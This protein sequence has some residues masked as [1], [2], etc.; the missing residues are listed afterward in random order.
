VNL[1]F[2]APDAYAKIKA[3][4]PPNP[5]VYARILLLPEFLGFSRLFLCSPKPAGSTSGP[6]AFNESKFFQTLSVAPK[7]SIGPMIRRRELRRST[8]RYN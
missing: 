8:L 1:Q 4:N 5:A 2:T 7:R 3:Y 6:I